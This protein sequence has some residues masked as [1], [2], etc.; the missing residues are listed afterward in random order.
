M[1]HGE[2]IEIWSGVNKCVRQVSSNTAIVEYGLRLIMMMII[3]DVVIFVAN[4]QAIFTVANL[5]VVCGCEYIYICDNQTKVNELS[6]LFS[7]FLIKRT[8]N[9][10]IV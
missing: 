7:K 6:S 1:T 8:E 9:L 10:N 5:C 3:L 2:M 4:L